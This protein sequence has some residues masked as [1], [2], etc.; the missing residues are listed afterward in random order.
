MKKHIP[1]IFFAIIL[2]FVT[3]FDSFAQNIVAAEYFFDIDPGVGNAIPIAIPIGN[4]ITAPLAISTVSLSNGFHNLFFRVKDSNGHWSLYTSRTIYIKTPSPPLPTNKQNECEYFFNTDPGVGIATG[5]ATFNAVNDTTLTKQVITSNY[6]L[7]PGFNTLFF[8]IKNTEGK[9]GLYANRTIYVK[10]PP[11]DSAAA[12]SYGEYFFDTDPGVG[13]GVPFNFPVVSQKDTTI[14]INI[15]SLSTGVHNIFFRFRDTLGI[16]SLYAGRYFRICGVTALGNFS[17]DTVCLGGSDSTNFINLSTGGDATTTYN[18]DFDGN[19]TT[20]YQTTGLIG[21]G[22]PLQFKHKYTSGGT[23]QCRLI[24]DNGGMCSDTTTKVVIVKSYPAPPIPSGINGLCINSPNTT[25]TIPHLLGATSYFW[26]ISPTNAGNLTY[27]DTSAVIDWNNTYTGTVQLKVKANYGPCTS[28]ESAPF[29]AILS[30]TISPQTIG[31]SVSVAQSS[32]CEGSATGSI[33]L[34]G[35]TGTILRWQKR[36]NSGSW[37]NISFS[38]NVYS[39]PSSSAGI[40]DYRA[41]IKNGACNDTAYSNYATITVNPKPAAAGTIIGANKVCKG[42]ELVSYYIP[43]I[44]GATSY[45]WNLPNG[46]SFSSG[47]T[48][49]TNSILISFAAWANSGSISVLGFNACGMG[50]VSMP[51][52]INVNP[53]P[54]ANAGTNTLIWYGTSTTLHGTASSG[55]PPYTYSWT[56]TP[57]LVNPNLQ[58]PVTINLDNSTP[59]TLTVTDSLGCTGTSDVNVI[60]HGQPLSAIPLA[61]PMIICPGANSQLNVLPN[62]GSGVYLYTWSSNPAGFHSTVQNPVVTPTITTQYIVV[63]N[64]GS[65]TVSASVTVTISPKPVAA[66]TITGSNTV[67]QGQTGVAYSVPLITNANGYTWILPNGA[68]IYS[69]SNTNTIVVNFA[70]NAPSGTISVYGTNNCGSGTP[71]QNYSVTVNHVPIANAGNTQNITNGTHATLNGSASGGSGNYSYSWAPTSLLVNANVQNPQTVNLSNSNTFSLTVT[72]NQTSCSSTSSVLVVVTG[73]PLS[74][75]TSAVPGTIC[76]GG[77]SQISA[78]P[79]G[80][81]G[82]YT[83]LWSSIPA[84]LNSTSQS[85]NVSPT[86][87]TTYTV[88]VTAGAQTASSNVIVTVSPMPTQVGQ[89]TGP[90]VVCKGDTS[91]AYSVTAIPGAYTYNWTLP[92]GATMYSGNGTNTILVNYGYNA[93]SGN[94]SVYASNFCGSGPVSSNYPITVNILPNANAGNDTVI[95]PGGI[96]T[97][98]GSASGGSGNYSYAWTPALLLTNANTTNP[99]TIPLNNSTTFT[100][101]VTDNATG[102]TK[103]SQVQVIISGGPLSATANATPQTICEGASAQLNALPQGG[104]VNYTYSWTSVPVGFISSIKNPTVYP[105][106]TTLY[107]VIVFD[108]NTQVS[109]STL[110]SINPLPSAAGVITGDNQV[111]RGETGIIYS[112]PNISGSTGYNWML[113]SGAILASGSNTSAITVNYTLSATSGN[114]TVAGTNFCGTG[115][116]SAPFQVHV[117]TLP[118]VDAGADIQIPQNGTAQLN[119]TAYG[120]GNFSYSWTPTSIL[121]NPIVPNPTTTQMAGSAVFTLVATDNLTGCK[122]SDQV[123][124]IVTGVPLNV[125]ASADPTTICQSGQ[126][127]LYALPT[128]GTG[129]YTYSWSSNPISFTSTAQ[130]PT[131]APTVTTQYTVVINDGSTTASSAITV[132]INTLPGN[133][134]QITGPASVCRGENGVSYTIPSITGATTYVWSLPSGATIASGANTNTINVNFSPTAS[135]GLISVYG[136]N[137]CGSGVAS[138]QQITV[139]PLPTANAGSSVFIQTGHQDT[140]HGTAA[141]GSGIYSYTWAPSIL[142]DSTHVQNPVTVALTNPTTFY[143]TVT[144]ASSGCQGTSDVTIYIVGGPLSVAATASPTNICQG[145][146]STL[147]AMPTGGVGNYSYSWASN[148]PNFTSTLQNPIVTPTVTTTYSVTVTSGASTATTSVV[149]TVN[150]LAATPSSISGTSTICQGVNNI[151]YTVSPVTGATSYNWTLPGG[152]SIVGGLG[153]NSIAVDFSSGAQSGIITVSGVNWCGSGPPSPDFQLTVNPSPVVYAGADQAILIGNSATLIGSVSGGIGPFSYLWSPLVFFNPPSQAHTLNATT[154]NISSSQTFTLTVVDSTTG[155]SASDQMNVFIMG[156]PLTVTVNTTQTN[157]CQGQT[158]Q[159]N[160]LPSG[161]SGN[162]QYTWSSFPANFTSTLQNPSV[163]PT[164]TTQYLLI[165][166][167]GFDTAS[168]TIVINVNPQPAAAGIITG[169]SPVCQGATSVLYTVSPIANATSYVWN[170]P[171]G[172]TIVSGNGTNAIHVDVASNAPSGTMSVYGTNNC[173]VGVSSPDLS[174]SVNVSPFAYTSADQ[175]VPQGSVI[176]LFGHA[177]NGSNSYTYTWSPASMLQD[178][179]VQNPYTDTLYQS[180]IFTLVVT[181]NV[182]GCQSSDIVQLIVY[183]GPLSVSVTSNVYSICAG[184]SVQLNALPTGGNGLYYYDWAPNG[185]LNNQTIYDP[186]ATPPATTQYTVQVASG[187]I[188]VTNSLLITVYQQAGNAGTITGSSSVCQGQSGVVFS[189]PSITNATTYNWTVPYGATIVSGSNSNTIMVNFG[190]NANSGNISVYGGNMCGYGDAS[191]NFWVTV[192]PTPNVNAGV[193]QQIQAGDNTSLYGLVTGG[194]SGYWYQWTPAN[195]LIN[196]SVLSPITLN[197]SASQIFTFYV[198]DSVTGCANSDYMKVIICGGPL[199]VDALVDDSIICEGQTVQLDA[200]PSGGNCVA[201]SYNWTSNPTGFTSTLVNTVATPTITTTY[202]VHYNDGTNT[203]TASVSVTVNPLVGDAGDIQG[204]SSVCQNSGTKTY[205]I[206]PIS[207][208]TSYVWTFPQGTMIISNPDSN[209]VEVIF[210]D[211]TQSGFINVYGTSSCGFG[212]PAP[213]FPITVK[214]LPDAAGPITGPSYMTK[215]NTAQFSIPPIPGTSTYYWVLPYGAV[216]IDGQGTDTITVQFTSDCKSGF[217]YAYGINSCGTGDPSFEHLLTIVTSITELYGHEI[218]LYPNPSN[219][220]F[221]LE[222]N[223]PSEKYEMKILNLYGSEIFTSEI[224]KRQNHLNFSYLPNGMYYMVL[225]NDKSKI[226]ER[227]VIVK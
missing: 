26:S 143:L 142:L 7:S 72:D 50:T 77:S 107:T 196:A 194:S 96:T 147:S 65:Q 100:L 4:D 226:I 178:N 10:G 222:L 102:C 5:F 183:G 33:T 137:A 128:G 133:A 197:L 94:I 78:L 104:T 187:G 138:S 173:G 36:H 58:N 49:T 23:F 37:S 76:Q 158:V 179:N 131:V 89:I 88:T 177:I 63:V 3:T 130:N 1:Y 149:V 71:S 121:N 57:L 90:N 153:T 151:I 154:V 82:T 209:V 48:Q 47:Q 202:T 69:G 113:P 136:S 191:P 219:G 11:K 172:F 44:T 16:N 101:Y 155:C 144:D 35:Y 223:G 20:D 91:V 19:G 42:Q 186:I 83:Y 18:W 146:S 215:N 67:C 163:S 214:P 162:Y 70:N 46:A 28:V 192:N 135:S 111:C 180:T 170:L 54:T 75:T 74:A 141:G 167:D 169:P 114:I 56:P 181:D 225:T 106:T 66:G 164:V 126:S 129:A 217:I 81:S 205:S 148:P 84:G 221:T 60:V 185:S 207:G 68:T 117:D 176:Q 112:I 212:L 73:F 45:T 127:T 93:I 184:E 152:A 157:I 204:Q 95:S 120:S 22:T 224:V 206:P 31:G 64:D 182:T 189:V 175:Y 99:T 6:N 24:T 145:Q 52:G 40:W 160:A 98:H 165:V 108:G 118:L 116:A 25:Y 32:I 27:T 9:W 12:L 43:P 17:A 39:E 132:T 123:Q 2:F 171:Q 92:T 188:T 119:G 190:S 55:T 218:K 125:N 203:T 80:G 134:G 103:A 41:V 53:S 156:G 213:T 193:D 200:L 105:D 109:A 201:G 59:F 168:T 29:S 62:G 15:S 87:T 97:L 174:I 61:D 161:G 216:I 210:T 198:T 139:K 208:A 86:V 227:F 195:L 30:I 140:L 13:N 166:S 38:S 79:S 124:V 110:V 199:T 115:T 122:N 150:P 159:L 14:N 51:Y 8:R 21:Q 211:S 220:E 85:P 34:S